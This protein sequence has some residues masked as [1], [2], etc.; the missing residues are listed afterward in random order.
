MRTVRKILH[1]L[2][3]LA[4][5]LTVWPSRAD[6]VENLCDPAY[7]D[8]R[9]PLLT[10]IKSETKGIDVAFWFMTDTR[11]SNAIISRWKAGVP[12][13][14]LMDTEANVAHPYNATILNQLKSA[15]IPMR[16]KS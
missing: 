8:C 15:G 2:L 4:V 10:L 5:A 1:V 9:V 6:A 7:E 14:V 13:R 12:V 16:Q 11:Y 3:T